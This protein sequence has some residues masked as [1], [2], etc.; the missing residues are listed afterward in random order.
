MLIMTSQINHNDTIE[1]FESNNYF[2]ANRESF[3]FFEQAVLPAVDE[4]GKILIEAPNKIVLSPNGNGA[5]FDSVA[6]HSLV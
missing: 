3:I 2:G 1:F 6:K 4:N 5:L